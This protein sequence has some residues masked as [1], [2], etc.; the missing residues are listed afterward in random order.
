MAEDDKKKKP[1][2]AFKLGEG[3]KPTNV[4]LEPIEVRVD[5]ELIMTRYSESLFMKLSYLNPTRFNTIGLTV[6]EIFAYLSFLV[7]MRIK[8]VREEVIDW[9]RLKKL[10]MPTWI[11]FV[12]TCIG[13]VTSI[14]YGLSFIP[15]TDVTPT[16]SIQEAEVISN[17][18][19]FF[20]PDGLVLID[21]GF[22]TKLEGDEE[23]MQ[24]CIIDG[25][26]HG[27]MPNLHPLLSYVA[28]FLGQQLVKADTYRMLY[29]CR[30]EEVEFM[31]AQ[32]LAE[33]A[34]F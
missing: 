8:Q 6:Q 20:I 9:R 22:P 25:Y 34:V 18:L 15:M 10:A 23:S 28:A 31:A 1:L 17:K 3:L 24:F 33:Q 12:I 5:P 27:R 2:D 21:S 30:Y 19:R 11:Q 16:I 32:I 14:E 13:K 4:K 7:V 29:R 26:V